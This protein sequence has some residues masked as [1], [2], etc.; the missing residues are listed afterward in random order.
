[1]KTRHLAIIHSMLLAASL[2]LQPV[3]ARG[4]STSPSELLE[5]GI[6]AEETKGDIEGAITIYQQLV[7]DAKANQSLAAKAHLRL[8]QCL[9]KKNRQQ[10]A[11]AA[12][13]KLIH[14]FPNEKELIAKAR[15][16][17]PGELALG[18]VPWVDGERLQM[19]LSL[20]AGLDIGT[21][22]L[23]ADLVETGGRKAWRVGRRMGGTGEM[24][25][26]VDVDPEN[27][28]PLA[29]YWKHT[30][31]GEAS[32]VFKPGEVEIRRAGAADSTTLRPD[33]T[34]FDNE[35]VMHMMRR[36]PLQTGYKTT[37]PVITTLGGGAILAIG[38]DVPKEETVE[39]PAGTYECF[40]VVLNIGQT[41]WISN[42]EHRYLVKFDAGGAI[43]HLVSI[44]QRNSGAAVPFR[45]D[46]LGVRLTTPADWVIHLRAK[47]KP[48]IY[49]LDP[50]ANAEHVG[51][52]LV[53]ADSIPA[54]ARQSA[55]ALADHDFREN[56][57]KTLKDAKVRPNSWKP[58]SV[59]GRTGVSFVA[60]YVEGDKPKVIFS[61]YAVGARTCENFVLAC[62]PEKLDE[63][64]KEFDKII[65]SYRMTK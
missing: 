63:L 53:P 7:A 45:D 46:R 10:D 33:K 29:S 2:T 64:Q 34:V 62:A 52:H 21:M 44:E 39:T 4:D 27:F 50:A 18:P 31:L 55:R 59:S 61:L 8:G 5:K 6:Y 51:L 60:D 25:S 37:L 58:Y 35:E 32:A 54:A 3:A 9:L 26:S 11:M 48:V 30:L 65:A 47:D 38:V 49:L 17:L 19:T 24:L 16:Y 57:Q 20:A 12:F 1:M 13:E 23:R 28:H 22:E 36:L 41:F 14:D 43:A 15:E 42:D 56:L 40:K